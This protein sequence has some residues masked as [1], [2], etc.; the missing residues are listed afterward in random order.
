MLDFIETE[1]G[2]EPLEFPFDRPAETPVQSTPISW[3]LL[4]SPT[5]EGKIVVTNDI[6]VPIII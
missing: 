2:L 3:N 5:T 4:H 1:T 6:F